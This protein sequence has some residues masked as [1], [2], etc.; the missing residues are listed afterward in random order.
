MLLK[1]TKASLQVQIDEP[2]DLSC[3]ID[4]GCDSSLPENNFT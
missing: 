3:F 2:T 4:S 1:S